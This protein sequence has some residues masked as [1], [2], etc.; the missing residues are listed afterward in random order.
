MNGCFVCVFKRQFFFFLILKQI[1][2]LNLSFI[3]FANYIN[4]YDV[5]FERL[6]LYLGSSTREASNLDLLWNEREMD[7]GVHSELFMVYF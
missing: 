1:F 2:V 3:I 6:Q 7:V 4:Y 5:Y